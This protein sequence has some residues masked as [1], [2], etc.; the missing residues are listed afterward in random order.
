MKQMITSFTYTNTSWSQTSSCTSMECLLPW[1]TGPLHF[2]LISLCLSG[3]KFTERNSRLGI[4]IKVKSLF[5][6]PVVSEY[7][8]RKG[9]FQFC[10]QIFRHHFLAGERVQKTPEDFFFKSSGEILTYTALHQAVSLHLKQLVAIL[11]TTRST[12][13]HL[14]PVSQWNMRSS[15]E[16]Q[17]NDAFFKITCLKR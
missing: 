4:V 6:W 5:Q 13:L 14:S 3:G 1:G 12:D 8:K 2:L 17:D 7:T 16:R 15:N 11:F 10:K 9:F